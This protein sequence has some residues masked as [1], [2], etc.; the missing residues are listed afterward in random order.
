MSYHKFTVTL[1][2]PVTVYFDYQGYKP[3]EWYSPPVDARVDIGGIDIVDCALPESVQRA[4]LN[5]IKKHGEHAISVE[6]ELEEACW[7]HL[8]EIREEQI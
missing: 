7:D 3:A 6:K 8:E 2:L 4:I 5:H 1:D